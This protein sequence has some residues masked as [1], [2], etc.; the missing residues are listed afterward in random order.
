VQV[1]GVPLLLESSPAIGFQCPTC[2]APTGWE[3]Q[4][5][6]EAMAYLDTGNP[7]CT[8]AFDYFYWE[9]QVDTAYDTQY[10]PKGAHE[11][12]HSSPDVVVGE[13]HANYA[14]PI[15]DLLVTM[16]HEASHHLW[17]LDQYDAEEFG[18]SCLVAPAPV[19]R[20]AASALTGS[21]APTT[22]SVMEKGGISIDSLTTNSLT[23]TGARAPADAESLAHDRRQP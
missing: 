17:N 22:F 19:A 11:L 2:R 16:L 14:W 23:P 13:Y 18:E 21:E 6:D 3:W 4:Q 10:H 15:W 5:I 12:D 8:E 9:F 1:V 20:P 7:D